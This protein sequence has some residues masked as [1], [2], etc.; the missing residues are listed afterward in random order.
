MIETIERNHLVD[1]LS[2]DTLVNV[3]RA[4]SMLACVDL[5]DLGNDDDAQI[6]FNATLNDAIG[7]LTACREQLE[8]TALKDAG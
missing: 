8:A 7:A 1:E 4:L 2:A 3:T 5:D 6:A